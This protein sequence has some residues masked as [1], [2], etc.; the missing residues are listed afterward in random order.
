MLILF[1]L[2]F[3]P[4]ISDSIRARDLCDVEDYTII[5]CTWTEGRSFNSNEPKDIVKLENGMIFRIPGYY[6]Y[7]SSSRA[8]VFA[9]KLEPRGTE[10]VIYKIFIEDSDQFYSA[11]RIR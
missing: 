4:R 1:I 3:V 5:K 7:L 10:I 6:D 2:S 8:V 9:R 11:Y